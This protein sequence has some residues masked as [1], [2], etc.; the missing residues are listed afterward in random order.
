MNFSLEIFLCYATCSY[1]CIGK[2]IKARAK[3]D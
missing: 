3:L 1:L 2:K